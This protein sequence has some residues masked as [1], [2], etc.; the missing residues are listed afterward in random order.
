MMIDD[1]NYFKHTNETET[2]ASSAKS[3]RFFIE[4]LRLLRAQD[5]S[6]KKLLVLEMSC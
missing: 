4:I 3:A 5:D 6:V 2:S 1:T